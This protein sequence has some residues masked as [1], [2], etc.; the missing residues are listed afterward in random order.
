[1][2]EFR[3]L[4]L[5]CMLRV[6]VP[7]LQESSQCSGSCWLQDAACCGPSA[8]VMLRFEAIAGNLIQLTAAA[9]FVV[10]RA[11]PPYNA[12]CTLT[13]MPT[14]GHPL[15]AGTYCC[16]QMGG[17]VRLYRSAASS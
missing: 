6:P 2:G 4:Y 9:V 14:T 17:V 11:W 3:L 15:M 5:L 12:C 10:T 13:V 16:I 7:L 1:M 8:F